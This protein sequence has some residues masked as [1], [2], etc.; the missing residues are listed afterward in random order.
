LNWEAEGRSILDSV[1]A[2]LRAY[3]GQ[4]ANE[5]IITGQSQ[6][7]GSALGA[8]RIASSYA[9]T[10]NLRAT[11]ATGV[12]S[13]FPDGPLK[14]GLEASNVNWPPRFNMVRLIGGSIPDGGPTADSLVTEKGRPLLTMARKSC[15]DEL[16]H[17]EQSADIDKNNAFV[18]TPEKL[19][20]L[21]VQQTN[22][23]LAKFP[24]PLF[25][26]TGLADHTVSPHRQYAAVAAL[27]TSGNTV[28][29]KRYG[30]IT[31]NGGVNAAFDDELGFVRSAL[32]GVPIP[33]ECDALSDPANSEAPTPGIP[34]ND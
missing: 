31:H 1:R 9:P 22:M 16:R 33:S 3:P 7:S 2:A 5:V 19:N 21:M 13:T 25:I 14:L 30:G 23:S 11:I 27:C 4:V 24:T 28:I 18:V 12:A 17:L 34:Y 29:W 15:I 6:G 20:A 8:S 10:L 26:G 32:A